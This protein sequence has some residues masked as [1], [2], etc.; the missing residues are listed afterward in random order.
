MQEAWMSEQQHVDWIAWLDT[1]RHRAI[2]FLI[3]FSLM[4]GV[5][6]VLTSILITTSSAKISENLIPYLVTYIAALILFMVQRVPDKWRVVAFIHL[7][8]AFG[9]F[10]LYS[11]WLAS[12]GRVVLLTMIVVSAVFIGSNAGVVATIFVV[13]IY[14]MFAIAF[15]Q[16]WIILRQLP[17]P[18][19][20]PPMLIEGVGFLIAIGIVVISQWFFSQA[21]HAAS[22]ANQET[23]HARAQLAEANHQLALSQASFANIVQRSIDGIIVID[24]NGLVQF[25]NPAAEQYFNRNR[26]E[27][28][29]KPAP[30]PVVVDQVCELEISRESNE[31]G[32]AELRIVSSEWDGKPAYLALL[33]DITDRQ[34]AKQALRESEQKFRAIIEQS[35][36]GIMLTDEQ[37]FIIEWNPAQEKLGITRE[38]A[39][40][41]PVWD[42][43]MQFTPIEQRNPLQ[44][45]FLKQVLESAL[46]TGE[47]DF[48][49]K[50]SEVV[51]QVGENDLRTIQRTAFPIKTERGYRISSVTIDVTEQ[52]RAEQE[53]SEILTRQAAILNNIPD[54]AWLKDRNN[55]FIAV[56]ESLSRALGISPEEMVGKTDY[57]YWNVDL[58]ERYRQDDLEVMSTGTRK[59]VES[60]IATQHGN[61][62]WTETIT[63]PLFDA[64]HRVVGTTG[65]SRDITERKL[66]EAEREKLIA[67]L[68]A[69]NA[70][71]ERFTYTVSH[72]LKSPLVTI[73][74]FLG[75]LEK[76]ML[77][78]NLELMRV[79]MARIVKAT[80]RMQQLLN[81]LLELS[82]IGRMMNPPVNVSLQSI[83]NQAVE[84]V[85]G[86]LAE[87]GITVIIGNNLPIV[88]GD[89]ARLVEAIQNLIDN[90]AKFMLNQPSPKIEIGMRGTDT[91][92]KPICYVRDNGIGIDTKYHERVFG[93]FNKLN[94]ES[95]GTGVGLALVKRII[96]VH[97][98]K[99]WIESEGLGKGSTFCFT[100][101]PAA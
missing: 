78:G 100:L 42:V 21:L 84:M 40:G 92:G 28:I 56:N 60:Q 14:V 15:G 11:G 64:H 91:D 19:T 26:S 3:G 20:F 58:A 31:P 59:R 77:A 25:T 70:E 67:E 93:L 53:R 7:L 90:A 62:R 43:M 30:F 65:I 51:I 83:V 52:R 88:H 63:T 96:E 72:D 57:D 24:H 18:T 16:H 32:S 2:N 39:I 23:Q 4:V 46:A 94:A 45:D 73:R 27:F 54:M 61:V 87:K 66:A 82:R 75:Y 85:Q 95:E 41:Q 1:K 37:G 17:D 6:G 29:A 101:P 13:G 10:A 55:R 34:R 76:S 81:E 44:R 36:E 79:D 48:L 12:S 86:R 71:L 89:V 80:D 98:G 35:V 68:E 49:G 38:Q 97:N 5:V 8:F 50:P 74:G 47:A 9:I 69:K 33:R 99:I 22:H